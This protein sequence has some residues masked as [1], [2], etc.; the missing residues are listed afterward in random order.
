VLALDREPEALAR[1]RAIAEPPTLEVRLARLED[2]D[3]PACDLVNASFALP[4]CRRELFPE[5]WKQIV[6]SLRPGGRFCGQLFGEHDDWAGSGVVVHTR[7]EVRELLAPFDVERLDE[8]DEDGGT[9]V[10]TRKH[11]HL[12]HVVARR[13]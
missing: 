12:Y 11:W 1:L 8:V 5:L 2:A 10:G 6:A 13:L 9:T 4:F 7:D 3:W